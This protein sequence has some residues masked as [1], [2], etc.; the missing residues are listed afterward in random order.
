MRLYSESYYYK[1]GLSEVWLNRILFIITRPWP[2]LVYSIFTDLMNKAST[3]SQDSPEKMS[4]VSKGRD[5]PYV[6][7]GLYPLKSL[8]PIP[9]LG[10]SDWLPVTLRSHPALSS[11][12]LWV[13]LCGLTLFLALSTLTLHCNWQPLVDIP[14]ESVNCLRW[15]WGRWWGW[16]QQ[17]LP[18]PRA[19]HI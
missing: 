10:L 16:E 13:G 7:L 2:G 12:S 17:C 11:I 1:I 5:E 9:S 4:N 6:N 14:Q 18:Q 8:I 15:G 19:W 3:S